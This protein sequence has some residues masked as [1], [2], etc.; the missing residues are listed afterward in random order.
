MLVEVAEQPKQIPK[1][2]WQ[3]KNF[4]AKV[5][6]RFAVEPN[7]STLKAFL[8][9]LRSYQEMKV[10]YFSRSLIID[11]HFTGFIFS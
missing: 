10:V 2:K 3:V 11:G 7:P 4:L 5:K 1:E 8:N 9:L 6:E